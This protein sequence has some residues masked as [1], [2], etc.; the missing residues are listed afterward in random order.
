MSFKEFTR[1]LNESEIAEV[2][3]Y[4]EQLDEGV[5][6]ILKYL[7]TKTCEPTDSRCKDKLSADISNEI[8]EIAEKFFKDIN[9]MAK[10]FNMSSSRIFKEIMKLMG[11]SSMSLHKVRDF[12]A[13]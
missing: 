2:H 4:F 10:K 12:L 11:N 8:G 6:D 3:Q 1:E 7:I 9:S 5:I 13:N